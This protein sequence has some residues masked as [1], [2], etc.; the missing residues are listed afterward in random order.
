MQV[1]VE[2]LGGLER[3]LTVQVPAEKV[4]QEVQSRLASLARRV[5]LDGFRPGKVPFK[6]VQRMYGDQVRQ[7]VLGDLV[8]SSF[9]EA[10]LQHNLRPAAGPRIE[11]KTVAVGQDLE[12]YAIFEVFPEFKVQGLEGIKVERPVAEVAEADIDSMIE[13]L[14]QQ[15]TRWN[16]V[17]RAAQNGDRVTLDFEGKLEG[18]DFPGNKGENVPLVLGSG[19]MIPGF[20]EALIGLVGGESKTFMVTFPQDYPNKDLAGKPVSFSATVKTVAE[21]VLPEVDEAFVKSFGIDDG[22][23]ESLRK[24]LRENM[25]R[26]LKQGIKAVVKRQVMQGLLD[27]NPIDLPQALVREEIEQLARQ[28]HFPTAGK[29]S[30]ELEKTKAELFGE[31]AKRRVA[32]GLIVSRVVT[33]NALK[34]EPARVQAHLEG[35]AASYEDAGEVIRWYQQNPQALESIRGLALEEQVVDWLLERAQVSDKPSS[36]DEIMKPNKA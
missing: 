24:A 3:R 13:N 25:E 8:Q 17:S 2:E 27:A 23:V 9:Q 34:L 4:E 36:F 32:L 11:P 22:S 28:M 26:E 15:R 14:R 31:E 10:V 12:Y 19:R 7:E 18:A 33:E 20:E 29:S 5:K 16:E 6:V 1:S 21:P 35:I 30:E